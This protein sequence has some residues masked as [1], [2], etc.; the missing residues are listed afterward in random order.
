MWSSKF[1]RSTLGRVL[2]VGA[3]LSLVVY[4]G[5]HPSLT[6]LVLMMVGMVPAITGLAGMCLLDEVHQ[7][8]TSNELPGHPR[9]RRA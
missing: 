7:S 6:G 3:G 2:R 5:M 4:G 9:E 8:R 1:L